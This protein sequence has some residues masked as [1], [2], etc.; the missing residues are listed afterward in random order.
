MLVTEALHR[1][2]ELAEDVHGLA[3][4]T[5]LHFV[6]K[7]KRDARVLNIY[8]GT[9]EVQRF[10]LLKDLAAAPA[11]RKGKDEKKTQHASR[12]A[13]AVETLRG[14]VRQRLAARSPCSARTCGRTRTC[15]LTASCCRGVRLAEGGRQHPGPARLAEPHGCEAAA[16]AG[17]Q[18]VAAGR[19]TRPPALAAA[20]PRCAIGCIAR[21]GAGPSASRLLR[22]EVQAARLLFDHPVTAP[23]ALPASKITRPLTVLVVLE[24][25]TAELPQPLVQDGRLMEAH[26][27]LSDADGAALETAL[28]LRDVGAASVSLHVAA[29]GPRAAAPVLR[30]ALNL[31]VERARLV[32]TDTPPSTPAPAPRAALRWCC[33]TDRAFDLSGRQQRA[34]SE[35][36]LVDG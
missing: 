26:W 34:G 15:R 3:G 33:E 25:T 5:Q 14:G 12:E 22:P 16:T 6:E 36:G 29:V 27:S 19:R 21:R 11:A 17:R 8:E 4:Q 1:I 35:E 28:R 31:G 20:V 18:C 24:P 7:R 2:I 9:N 32:V 13:L 10:L 30:Q 23:V